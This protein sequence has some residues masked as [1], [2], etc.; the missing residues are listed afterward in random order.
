MPTKRITKKV[1]FTKAVEIIKTW[2]KF[3]DW[4]ITVKFVRDMKHTAYCTVNPEYKIAS[5]YVNMAQLKGLTH[6]EVVATALHELL[7]CIVWPLGEWATLLSNKDK[8]KIEITRRYEEEV[9]TNLERII[10][11]LVQVQL[12]DKLLEEGYGT[13]NLEFTDFSVNHM[14]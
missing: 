1:L 5:I 11:P 3:Q 6:N 2:F 8:H 14:N 7:H 4:K 9:V 13:V 12:N 10:L